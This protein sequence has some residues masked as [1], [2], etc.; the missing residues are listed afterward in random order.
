MYI[1][2]QKFCNIPGKHEY[3]ESHQANNI[4]IETKQDVENELRKAKEKLAQCETN[5]KIKDDKIEEMT[6]EILVLQ[7]KREKRNIDMKM[8]MYDKKQLEL[9]L[10]ENPSKKKI[11]VIELQ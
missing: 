8:L 4:K 9:R 3:F 5:S 10:N 6:K 7:R 2:N 11:R 1:E